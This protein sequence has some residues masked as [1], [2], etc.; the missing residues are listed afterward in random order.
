M[1]D[2]DVNNAIADPKTYASLKTQHDLFSLLRREDPVHWSEPDGYRPFW[3]ISKNADILEIERQPEVFI[4]GPRNKLWDIEFEQKVSAATGGRTQLGR[5]IA[6]M[7]APEHRVYRQIAQEW[8]QP[9][10]LKSLE[11]AIAQLARRSI[12]ELAE[13]TP[14]CDFYN[15]IALRFPMRVLILI[16]GLP[17][18]DEDQLLEITKRFFAGGDAE[19]A[20]GKDFI[21]SARDYFAYF[22]ALAHEK[23]KNP[24]NDV[25][26]LIANSMVDGQPI[27][28]LIA[29]SYFGA[30]ASA[31]HDT[32]SST[33]AGGLLALIE[34]PD[35]WNALKSNPG[36]VPSAVEEM[37]R[38]VSPV[39][40][41]MRTA[42]KDYVI[43]GR[44][45]R[46]GESL[47]LS[48]PSAN[49]DEDVFEDPWAFRVNRTPNKHLGFG[50]GPHVCLGLFLAR[51]EL[52]IFF[53]ELLPRVKGFE[54]NGEPRWVQTNF[55]GG[56][57]TLPVKYELA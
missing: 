19:L 44:T 5:S 39:K 8:F 35:Q 14:T 50:F 15:D 55:V 40:H 2:R 7:D 29:K 3:T 18:S 47:L 34:N 16:L 53:K 49:R 26:S 46:A 52:Q 45:I 48:Y 22:D 6:Q 25:A 12:D 1:L 51:Q 38:W 13:R 21:D 31:G 4:A 30:L 27:D 24:T 10:S 32:T 9:K 23:Q 41:F 36:L 33:T 20:N 28:P 42:T 56:L 17:K 43:R 54:L 37:L 57:K 11:P